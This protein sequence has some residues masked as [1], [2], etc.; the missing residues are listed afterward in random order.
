MSQLFFSRASLPRVSMATRAI[1]SRVPSTTAAISYKPN[2]LQP[3]PRS[4]PKIP[5]SQRPL[6]REPTPPP[7]LAPDALESMPYIVRRTPFAQLPVYR[8]W[9]S[10]GTRQVITIKK[11]S[12]DKAGLVGEL[13][14]KL[15]VPAGN[16]RINPTTGNLELQGD[17]F[18]KT[19]DYLLERGF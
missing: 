2:P 7:K 3:R 8:K 1:L 12:G 6:Y 10:G 19:R 11:V 18:N 16:I 14:E 17:F 4:S 5:Q 9:M 15:G 13:T